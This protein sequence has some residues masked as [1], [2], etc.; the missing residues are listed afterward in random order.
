MRPCA[1]RTI[2]TEAIR[3]L[4]SW[5]WDWCSR[6]LS[7]SLHKMKHKHTHTHSLL[8]GGETL[9]SP[10]L[11][12]SLC[13]KGQHCKRSIQRASN[14]SSRLW[15]PR[16]KSPASP[17]IFAD[18]KISSSKLKHRICPL[19]SPAKWSSEILSEACTRQRWH[20]SWPHGRRVSQDLQPTIHRKRHPLKST[21]VWV[22]LLVLIK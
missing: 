18:L 14:C 9:Q 16:Q 1:K 5:H 17:G 7:N 11:S 13:K 8:D 10:P 15:T 22:T 2:I 3:G 4:T 20:L 12:Y 6:A 19:C 21:S